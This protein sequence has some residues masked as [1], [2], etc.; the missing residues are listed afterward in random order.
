[1]TTDGAVTLATV[2]IE[3]IQHAEEGMEGGCGVGG[4][5]RSWEERHLAFRCG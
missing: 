3:V 4:D 2:L 5:E 1:V